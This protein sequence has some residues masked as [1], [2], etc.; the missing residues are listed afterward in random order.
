MFQWITALVEPAFSGRNRSGIRE[1]IVSRILL[2]CSPCIALASWLS[3]V[4]FTICA[5]C[6][7]SRLAKSST[8]NSAMS[9]PVQDGNPTRA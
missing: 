3:G 6:F 9:S 5:N 1:K 2:R 4:D 8:L 7:G